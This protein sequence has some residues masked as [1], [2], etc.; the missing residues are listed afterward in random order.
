SSIAAQTEPAAHE[1]PSR[2]MGKNRLGP[3]W[4][5]WL[6]RLFG[7]PSKRRLARGALRIN[8]IRYW[9]KE[10]SRLSDAEILA[11]GQRFKGRSRGGE[12]LDHL[13]PEVFGAVCVASMR[14]LGMRPFDVQLAAGVVLHHGALA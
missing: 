4:W 7:T 10:F 5:N 3:R 1:T 12:A 6:K 14:R 2:A 9:E 13:L 11:L 8:A